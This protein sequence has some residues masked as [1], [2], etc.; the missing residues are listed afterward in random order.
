MIISTKYVRGFTLIEI[1]I[2]VV[3]L[4]IL[5]AIALPKVIQNIDKAR[6]AEAFQIASKVVGAFHR[7][8]DEQTG[9]LRVARMP[10]VRSCDTYPK[11]NLSD[12][13]AQ[14]QNF[15]CTLD[16]SAGTVINLFCVGK[17]SGATII[18]LFDFQID[19]VLG[20]TTKTC[21]G[22]FTSMCKN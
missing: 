17:F 14:S 2:V 21:T 19:P 12:P 1:I 3:I 8:I 9:G 11:L 15:N 6:A 13:S 16:S 10:D 20:S 18:D 22:I 7:C 4:G 5:A